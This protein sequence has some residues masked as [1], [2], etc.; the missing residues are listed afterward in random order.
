LRERVAKRILGTFS[1]ICIHYFKLLATPHTLPLSLSSIPAARAMTPIPCSLPHGADTPR[2]APLPSSWWR[3]GRCGGGEGGGDRAS[4]PGAW[5]R[6]RRELTIV[7]SLLEVLPPGTRMALSIVV[8][9]DGG[10][11]G[12]CHPSVD[13]AG[14]NLR[15][16]SPCLVLTSR[17]VRGRAGT[18]QP[19]GEVSLRLSRA[20]AAEGSCS[21]GC[22]P[23]SVIDRLI[24]LC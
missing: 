6:G 9:C 17:R 20:P 24:L 4:G 22:A 10:L 16:P 5:L 7:Q 23:R 11:Q 8:A 1:A 13:P 14:G 2:L 19:L 15:H 21:L 3:D 12:A 18:R